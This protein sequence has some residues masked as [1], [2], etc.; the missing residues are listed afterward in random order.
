M[1]A[2]AASIDVARDMD[3]GAN[4]E[5]VFTE[6]DYHRD[7]EAT[8]CPEGYW[9]FYILPGDENFRQMIAILPSEY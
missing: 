8:D 9:K 4:G 6:V 3:T 1:K 2:G 5:P 7:I